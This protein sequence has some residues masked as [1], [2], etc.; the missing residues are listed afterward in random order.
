[1]NSLEHRKFVRLS[2]VEP[3]HFNHEREDCCHPDKEQELNKQATYVN[4]I[5]H[6]DQHTNQPWVLHRV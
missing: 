4:R 2:A 6:C 1:M 3:V 5:L